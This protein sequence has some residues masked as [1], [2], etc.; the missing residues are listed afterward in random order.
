MK[1]IWYKVIIIILLGLNAALLYQNHQIKAAP[2][3]SRIGPE[4][5]VGRLQLPDYPVTDQGGYP[6]DLLTLAGNSEHTM[7]IFFSPSDCPSCFDERHL[8]GQI[9]DRTQLP[10]V[11]IATSPDSRELWQWVD[12]M[13]MPIDIYLDTTF[14][15]EHTMEFQ[16]TPLKLLVNS[17][18]TIVWA[19]PPREPGSARE[20]F[21]EDLE[22]ANN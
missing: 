21:W 18:G 15:I 16:M 20:H 5:Y 13:E 9:T 19:D 8:W 7:F 10:V 1:T 12:N 4:A 22:N 3:N 2:T 14:V 6:T 11:G 17:S